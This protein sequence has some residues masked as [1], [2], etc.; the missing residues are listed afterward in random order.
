M[1]RNSE[2]AIRGVL[3]EMVFLEI[4]QNSQ[5]NTCGLQLY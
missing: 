4:P 3:Y 5:E 2:A 1:L